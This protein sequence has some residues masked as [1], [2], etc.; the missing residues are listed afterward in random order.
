[1]TYDFKRNIF[2]YDSACSFRLQV[3]NFF[4]KP[5]ELVIKKFVFQMKMLVWPLTNTNKMTW[6]GLTFV[7]SLH[8]FL[9]HRSNYVWI[10]S[11]TR[12]KRMTKKENFLEESSKSLTAITWRNKNWANEEKPQRYWGEDEKEDEDGSYIWC[13]KL[14]TIFKWKPQSQRVKKENVFVKILLKLVSHN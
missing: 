9:D 11:K 4:R 8:N 2:D 14:K 5:I 13:S 6:A 12:P 10:D 3:N 1:M 7:E